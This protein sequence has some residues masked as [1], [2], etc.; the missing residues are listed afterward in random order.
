[1][2]SLPTTDQIILDCRRELIETV[3]PA[4]SDPA[5]AVCIQ[6]MENVLRNTATRAAHEIAWMREEAAEMVSYAREVAAG[7]SA[8]G[9]GSS[10]LA[11]ALKAAETADT[12]SLHLADMVAA[13]SAA[14]EAFSCALEQAVAAG[15]SDHVERGVEMLRRRTE[16]EQEIKGDWAMI[17]RG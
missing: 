3:L 5:V 11:V 14:G 12:G 17:G 2:I 6:M 7:L 4:V 10:E 8:P 16:R 1:M 15:A 9:G 13:Y